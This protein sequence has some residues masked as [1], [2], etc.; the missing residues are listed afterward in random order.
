PSADFGSGGTLTIQ[1]AGSSLSGITADR[2]NL[3]GGLTLGGSSTLTLDL[4]GLTSTTGG[5]ITIVQDGSRTGTFTTVN[6]VNNPNGF[7]AVVGY[8]AT[9]VTVNVV[10]AAT[11]FSVSAPATATAGAP[12]TVTVT[13]L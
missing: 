9:T 7:Q 1:S 12:F 4:G 6:V 3:T 11:H 13:A 5:P 8:T 10:A 2:L